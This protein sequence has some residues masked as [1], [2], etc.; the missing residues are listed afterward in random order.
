[1]QP[2]TEEREEEDEGSLR[3]GGENIQNK[4]PGKNNQVVENHNILGACSYLLFSN[5]LSPESTKKL[6]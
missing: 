3:P 1:M 2:A 6:N 4:T 5:F